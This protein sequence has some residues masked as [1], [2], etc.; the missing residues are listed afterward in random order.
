M[1]KSTPQTG[2]S[3]KAGTAARACR[4]QTWK[5]HWINF[6]DQPWPR[7]CSVQP[8]TKGPTVGAHVF[9]ADVRG[10]QIVP[11]CASCN[12]LSGKFELK[13]EVCLVSANQ[14]ETCAA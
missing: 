3:N 1:N 12:M 9:H 11:M 13:S 4:C 14:A 8:C 2:W 10:E 6:A 5:Q 7:Q